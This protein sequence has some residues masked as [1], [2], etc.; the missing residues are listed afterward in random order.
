MARA[1]RRASTWTRWSAW[2]SGSQPSSDGS[3]PAASTEPAFRA[4]VS[5]W[6][7]LAVVGAAAFLL[8]RLA[9]DVRGKPLFEDEAV[10]GL[11]G[12]R[13]PWEILV[14]TLWD[15]GGAPLHFLLVHLAFV[16]DSSPEAL[17][18][19]SVVFALATVGVCYDLGRRLDGQVAGLTAAI[20]AACSG[21][22]AIYGSFG[23]MYAVLAFAAA[24][25]ADLF[26]RAVDLRT[27]EAAAIAA[28][29][30]WLLPAVH[31]YGGIVVAVEAVVAL[32]LWRGRPLRPAIPVFLIGAAMIPFAVADLRLA[33]RFEVSSESTGRLASRD[34][35]RNQLTDALRGF[36]GGSGWTFV[37]FLGLGIAGA[38]LLSRRQGAF[39]AWGL[40]AFLL[41]PLL[42][43][44]VHTGRA[45]DLSPRHLIFALP[46]WAAFIGT[47][48]AKL[49]LRAVAVIAVAVLAVI[50]P[51]G[52]RDP[53]S[54]TYTANLGTEEALAEPSA[55]LR[56]HVTSADLLYPY[57]SVFLAALPQ[58]GEAVALPRAQ[59]STLLDTLDRL[60]YPRA[61]I[62]VAVP[63]GTTE[64]DLAPLAGHNAHP[65][66]R[67]LL[68]EVRGEL[69]EPADVLRGIAEALTAARAALQPPVPSA[70]EGWFDLNLAVLC[71]S[72]TSLGS[73]CVSE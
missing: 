37:I 50:S 71:E 16:F 25:A 7:I 57:A 44:L 21:M 68:L 35:A 40:A 4:P 58:A 23:R 26:V 51:Q 45:P 53:R 60:D 52:I 42:A 70:L 6:A 28:A 31:P 15:R 8:A 27:A 12:A 55:W 2:L 59:K 63:T 19:L 66:P 64:V 56:A 1:S 14:T 36:A 48:V 54:I 62:F 43:T 18:W 24:V 69:N 29:G 41:P 38:V 49:P 17:R 33:N 72:L 30:A 39:V 32:A 3:F 10:A 9:P 61:R 46:F 11:I 34:E 13:P 73:E 22:L 5:R 65:F 47:A 67:W 20:V